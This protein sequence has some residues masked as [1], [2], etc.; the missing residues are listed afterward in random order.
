MIDSH[1]HLDFSAFD[2]DRAQLLQQC[3]ASGLEGLVVP[4]VAPDQWAQVR[5]LVAA[6]SPLP[7]YGSAGL[8]PWWVARQSLS[9]LA[10]AQALGEALDHCVAIGECG[11]DGGIDCALATQEL[12]FRLHLELA[13]ERSKP[14]IIHSHKAHS[15]VLRLLRE[16]RPPAGGVIHAFSGSA[17]IAREYWRLGFYL[18]VG[19]TITYPRA[20]KTRA[21]LA[22]MPLDSLLLET[23]A[24]DMPLCGYQGQRNSPLQLPKVA[25]CLAVLQGES[26][27]RVVERTATNTRALFGLH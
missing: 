20:R 10:F 5:R 21:A 19:G 7:L 22:A 3:A 14:L 12:W 1:C 16:Y 17:E 8:H 23:D 9:T 15:E 2:S 25:D 6:P 11:L 4:G 18:G 26:L 24:P 13:C 27:A